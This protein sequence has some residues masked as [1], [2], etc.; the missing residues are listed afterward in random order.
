MDQGNRGLVKALRDELAMATE[1]PRHQLRARFTE[2]QCQ[3]LR[4]ML[5]SLLSGRGGLSSREANASSVA[6]G[7]Y[8]GVT[9]W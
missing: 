1:Q 7:G 2:T 3:E 8:R 6:P 9:G 5:A 4:L